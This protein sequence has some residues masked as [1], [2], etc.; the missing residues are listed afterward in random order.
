[1]ETECVFRVWDDRRDFF[2]RNSLLVQKELIYQWTFNIFGET[3]P[4]EKAHDPD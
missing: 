1:M 3:P 2:L 4:N